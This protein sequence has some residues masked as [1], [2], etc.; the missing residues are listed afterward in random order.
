MEEKKLNLFELTTMCM[1]TMIG[2]GI[3][4]MMGSGIALTGRSISLAVLVGAAVMILIYFYQIAYA[5]MFVLNG[6]D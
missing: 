4:V 5:S 3:F 2:S 6:G 1:G